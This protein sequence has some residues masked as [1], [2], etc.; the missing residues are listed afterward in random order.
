MTTDGVNL[1][2]KEQIRL[3]LQV[4]NG[5]RSVLYMHDGNN[6]VVVTESAPEMG[7]ARAATGEAGAARHLTTQQHLRSFQQGVTNI[8]SG[9]STS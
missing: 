9:R 5:A 4:T 2:V 7:P 1:I 3:L 8:K 6:G